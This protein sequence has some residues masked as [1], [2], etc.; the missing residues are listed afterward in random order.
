MHEGRVCM[1]ADTV[2]V[3]GKVA[4]SARLLNDTIARGAQ[5]LGG[6]ELPI[7]FFCECGDPDCRRVTQLTV[8]EYQSHRAAPLIAHSAA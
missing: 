6:D 7:D 1:S 4:E 5:R 8:W 3:L 2:P